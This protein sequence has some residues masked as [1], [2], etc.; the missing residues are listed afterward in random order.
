M[1]SIIVVTYNRKLLLRGCLESIFA[2]NYKQPYEVVVINNGSTDAT[3]KWL[4]SEFSGRIKFINHESRIS[5][6][7]C[8]NEGF[9]ASCGDVI[10]FTD[11]DCAVV[12]GWLGN[13]HDSI[14]EYDMVGGVVLP[15]DVVKFP[16]WWRPSL[17]WIMGINSHPSKSYLPLGS[18]I[19][20][21]R[22]VFSTLEKSFLSMTNSGDCS[23][24]GEDN[25]R[26][27]IALNAGFNLGINKNMIVYH[28][29]P[30]ERLKIQYFIKR[31]YIEGAAWARR[32]RS[33]KI[34]LVRICALIVNPFRFLVTLDIN[35]ILRMLV[36]L[37]YILNY[38]TNRR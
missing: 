18:N 22:D 14:Q 25:Q 31:S 5:L 1:I 9:K 8:K 21:K 27:N 37:G 4:R 13:I 2:Q 19:A 11:D 16:W 33:F 38:L 7:R 15:Y 17:E 10:S 23:Q 24:Y 32:E 35:R 26:L 3:E 6:S 12:S 29:I 28:Q 36:S 20:Y 30:A 34:L